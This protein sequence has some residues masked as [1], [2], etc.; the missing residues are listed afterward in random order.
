M[1]YRV[2]STDIDYEFYLDDNFRWTWRPVLIQR[3]KGA[4]GAVDF[5]FIA[6]RI[7][8]RRASF[9]FTAAGWKTY[10]DEV[11]RQLRAGGHTYQVKTIKRIPKSAI[12]YQDAIQVAVLGLS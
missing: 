9:W 4:N 2:V 12:I 8:N 1:F 6:P 11:I 3:M 5:P 10:N 7:R